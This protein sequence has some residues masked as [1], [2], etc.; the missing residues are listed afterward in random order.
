MAR[1]AAVAPTP[2][3]PVTG[4][5]VASAPLLPY[6]SAALHPANI[7]AGKPAATPPAS[8]GTAARRTAPGSP[9]RPNNRTP[10]R[11][12]AGRVAGPNADLT[13]A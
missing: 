7:P 1:S 11:L 3:V 13:R 12:P 4:Q 10:E 9:E 2:T 8:S 5:H 6:A